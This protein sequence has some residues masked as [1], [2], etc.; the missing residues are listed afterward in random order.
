M[1][2]FASII[3]SNRP[4]AEGTW[5]MDFEWK[6]PSA[7]LPGQFFSLRSGSG[8]D[9]LLRRPFAFSGYDPQSGS[10]S[11]IYLRRGRTTEQLSSLAEGA[12]LDILGPLGRPFSPAADGKPCRSVLLSG[13]I[14]LGPILFLHSTLRKAG[15]EI[16]F[17]YGARTGALVPA[18][19][20]PPETIV[21]TDD[22]SLGERGTV[23][24]A[25]ERR[26]WEAGDRAYAC[27]PGPM[28]KALAS[29][30]L[31]AGRPCIVSVEQHM[32]CG[33]GACMGCAVPAAGGGYLR[34][35]A[36]GPVFNAE[37]LSWS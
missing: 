34:A 14:G 17:L 13:G 23:L 6:G 29:S 19:A 5:M 36:D 31:A 11:F 30:C 37:E 27:G 15:Q 22:G 18:T 1:K 25:M 4:L 20:L 16:L 28:L 3:R 33:V 24:D 26:G 9:P 10:A 32:A 12:P 8:T 21:C 2:Q 7:P 35:C